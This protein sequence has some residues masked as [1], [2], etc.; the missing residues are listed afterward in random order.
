MTAAQAANG[1]PGGSTFAEAFRTACPLSYAFQFD[2]VASSFQ[3]SNASGEVGYLVTFCP[4][5]VAGTLSRSWTTGTTTRPSRSMTP[6][7][8]P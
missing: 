4:G 7:V 6:H 8:P 2:D 3:C 5:E 1:T